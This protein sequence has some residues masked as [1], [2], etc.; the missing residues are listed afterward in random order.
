MIAGMQAKAFNLLSRHDE[1]PSFVD[2]CLE[3]LSVGVLASLMS[4]V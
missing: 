4:Q 2:H 3:A 1:I